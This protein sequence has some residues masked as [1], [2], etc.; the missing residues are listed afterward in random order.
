M[1]LPGDLVVSTGSGL[2]LKK[3]REHF[4][5]VRNKNVKH[6]V[7]DRLLNCDYV[8]VKVQRPGN[9]KNPFEGHFEVIE[10]NRNT[11]KIQ[12]GSLTKTVHIDL[13]KP[14]HVDDTDQL[15][16]QVFQ[17]KAYDII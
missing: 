4:D 1:R 6:F 5:S 16:N 10:K 15:Q 13:L 14:A 12:C 2:L 7:P 11:F 9:L 3:L 17:Q 8:F